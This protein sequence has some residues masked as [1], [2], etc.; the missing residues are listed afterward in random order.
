MFGSDIDPLD[1]DTIALSIDQGDDALFAEFGMFPIDHL[2]R[3][4]AENVPFGLFGGFA[5]LRFDLSSFGEGCLHEF[6]HYFGS[7][8]HGC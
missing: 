1:D 4:A 8:G 5:D 2:D 3:I 6:F 7:G